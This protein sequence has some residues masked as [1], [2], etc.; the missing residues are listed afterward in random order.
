MKVYALKHKETG[1]F[2]EG[3]RY[4]LSTTELPKKV[5]YSYDEFLAF[6][7]YY[8]NDCK[9]H[10]DCD[11]HPTCSGEWVQEQWV[12]WGIKDILKEFKLVTLEIEE[13]P[14][15]NDTISKIVK[16]LVKDGKVKDLK[17]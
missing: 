3:G 1:E 14:E 9:K 13:L 2:S 4:A 15:K 6:L 16:Q 11:M 7:K 17:E 10:R 12:G 5:W 8:I